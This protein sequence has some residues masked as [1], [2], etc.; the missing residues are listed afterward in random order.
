MLSWKGW[1][2]NIGVYTS[3]KKVATESI[4]PVV[5]SL[6]SVSDL[7]C[8]SNASVRR[9]KSLG[10]TAIFLNMTCFEKRDIAVHNEEFLAADKLWP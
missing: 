4:F 7:I 1:S 2:E 5:C 9:N 10:R 8:T 6:S 3:E